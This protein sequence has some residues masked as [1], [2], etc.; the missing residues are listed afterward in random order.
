MY[1]GKYLEKTSIDDWVTI[2][3]A[4][5]ENNQGYSFKVFKKVL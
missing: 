2:N 5:K 4:I 3:Q 1:I